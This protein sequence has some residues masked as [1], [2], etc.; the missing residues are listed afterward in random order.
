MCQLSEMLVDMGSNLMQV[1]NQILAHAQREKKACSSIVHSLE[2]LAWPQLHS[3]AQD[4][5]T[6]QRLAFQHVLRFYIIFI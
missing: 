4:L 1:D 3:H 2:T 6:V 5:S